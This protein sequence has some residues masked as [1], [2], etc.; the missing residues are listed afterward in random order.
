[1]FFVSK[2]F[3]LIFK[4]YLTVDK[5]V[6]PPDELINTTST[7][8]KEPAGPAISLPP[9]KKAKIPIQDSDDE[10][11]SI[12]A[13]GK[14]FNSVSAT[15]KYVESFSYD[16]GRLSIQIN[17]FDYCTKQLEQRSDAAAKL[18]KKFLDEKSWKAANWTLTNLSSLFWLFD[19]PLLP[20][21]TAVTRPLTS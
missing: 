21:E 16:P 6:Q 20:L 19:R 4:C 11:D 3:T 15:N 17:V 12:K 8:V 1:M 10:T 9:V 18:A 5:T 7:Y 13:N 14:M 2:A